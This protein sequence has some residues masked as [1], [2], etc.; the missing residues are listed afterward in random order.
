MTQFQMTNGNALNA[1]R[2]E[3]HKCNSEGWCPRHL[4]HTM[5][6][7][8]FNRMKNTAHN[9]NQGPVHSWPML[10]LWKTWI[11]P[12]KC[13]KNVLSGT[14]PVIRVHCLP[15]ESL[16]PELQVGCLGGVTKVDAHHHRSALSCWQHLCQHRRRGF[17]TTTGTLGPIQFLVTIPTQLVRL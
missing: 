3:H 8:P 12:T 1:S 11:T 14:G 13:H 7:E 4:E 6:M 16:L 17:T 10:L 5:S 2:Q 9:I 15:V